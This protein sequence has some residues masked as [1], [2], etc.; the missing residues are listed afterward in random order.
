MK[1]T[2][3]TRNA[4]SSDLFTDAEDTIIRD[5]VAQHKQEHGSDKLPTG[6]W[7]SV[8]ENFSMRRDAGQLSRR[9]YY[10][11]QTSGA[12][13]ATC[14][15]PG[16]F[17]EEEIQSMEK[18]VREELKAAG[19]ERVR[20]GFWGGGL[21]K[22][23]SGRNLTSKALC[24][25]YSKIKK[26]KSAAADESSLAKEDAASEPEPN[27]PTSAVE[28]ETTNESSTADTVPLTNDLIV[29]PAYQATTAKYSPQSPV[30]YRPSSGKSDIFGRVLEVG[31]Y[32][33]QDNLYVYTIVDDAGVQQHERIPERFLRER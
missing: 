9:W 16:G 17:S 2:K 1:V 7:P 21:Q 27:P 32:P 11:K 13:S 12:I 14:T 5:A 18:L 26:M 20:P 33:S 25:L 24:K 6:F 29:L 22:S 19:S 30:T 10:L 8:V 3:D 28:D 31:I 4:K 23:F 15:L